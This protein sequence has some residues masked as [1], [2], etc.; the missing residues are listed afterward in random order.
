MQ[1]TGRAIGGSAFLLIFPDNGISIAILANSSGPLGDTGVP[2]G[3]AWGDYDN[4]G[5]LDL[6]LADEIAANKLLQND[7]GGTFVDVTNGPLGDRPGEEG[8]S[9]PF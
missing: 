7:G 3:L 5:D 1:H 6:Y 2:L 8:D 4:D 9:P